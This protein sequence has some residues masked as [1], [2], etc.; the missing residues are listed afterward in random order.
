V[1]DPT[2]TATFGA[3]YVF[4]VLDQREVAMPLRVNLVLSPRLSVQL[5]TQALLSAG[6]YGPIR[7]FAMPR[8]YHFVP[9]SADLGF[10]PEFNLKALRANMVARWEFR[11]GSTLYLVWTQRRQDDAYAG[12]SSFG[13][14]A[15]ELFRA[16]ADDVL[17][18]KVAWWLGL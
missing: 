18:I 16:P 11:P 5:Y 6:D 13:R 9:Y 2:A 10:D 7:Q 3:R 14:D 15:A 1:P 17:M 4:G 8:T 12:D